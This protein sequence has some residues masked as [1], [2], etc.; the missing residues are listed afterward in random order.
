MKYTILLIFMLISEHLYSQE[1]KYSIAINDGQII[2]FPRFKII[3]LND[4]LPVKH[5]YSYDNSFG[6]SFLLH[7]SR[8]NFGLDV[9]VDQY[10]FGLNNTSKIYHSG[11]SISAGKLG[12]HWRLFLYKTGIL[13]N[14]EFYNWRKFKFNATISPTFGWYKFIDNFNKYENN[15]GDTINTNFPTSVLYTTL[16]AY[17]RPGVYFLLRGSIQAEYKLQK[18]LNLTLSM[19]YQQGFKTFFRDSTIISLEYLSNKPS[20]L[21]TGDINGTS[22][23]FS[24]GLKYYFIKNED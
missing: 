19:G 7:N 24:L 12:L 9:N 14:K 10:G 1:Y 20:T 8:C 23:Q 15:G 13:I 16:P 2:T 4:N 22:I 5:L 18:Q 21:Y 17:Q 3:P 11:L 6:A